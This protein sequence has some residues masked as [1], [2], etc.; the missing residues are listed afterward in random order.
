MVIPSRWSDD[1]VFYEVLRNPVVV[2]R[3]IGGSR[4]TFLVE[5]TIRGFVH[6]CTLDDV[7]HVLTHVPNKHWT[8]IELIILRQPTRK[9]NQLSPVWGRL[10]YYADVGRFKGPAIYLEAQDPEETVKWNRSLDRDATDELERL[11]A[12]GHEISREKRGH[13]IRRSV[14]S[15]RNTQLYRTLLHEIGHEVDWQRSVVWPFLDSPDAQE[16]ER[17]QQTYWSRPG[18]E[19]EAFAHRYADQ[20]RQELEGKGV[21]PFARQVSRSGL[22]SDNL[23]RQWFGLE[24]ASK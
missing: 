8:E 3:H 1:R 14:D 12:D 6:A 17:A 9:Q 16:E 4:V 7:C 13:T 11:K 18:A 19:R 22:V 10:V 15:I 5:P 2:A 24:S 21:V 23:D 20:M